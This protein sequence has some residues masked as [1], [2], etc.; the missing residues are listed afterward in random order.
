MK[1]STADSMFLHSFLVI[2]G[3]EIMGDLYMGT[4]WKV[5]IFLRGDHI[6]VQVSEKVF[7]LLLKIT[8]FQGFSMGLSRGVCHAF[9]T[10]D[11]FNFSLRCC[12]WA[13][14]RAQVLCVFIFWAGNWPGHSAIHVLTILPAASCTLSSI[15]NTRRPVHPTQL[16]ILQLSISHAWHTPSAEP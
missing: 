13:S 6:I 7:Y 8:C 5:Y 15:L 14:G 9:Q 1:F 16:Q 10:L 11:I 4:I 3:T 12:N 2:I